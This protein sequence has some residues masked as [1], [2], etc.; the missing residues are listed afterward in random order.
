MDEEEKIT[1]PEDLQIE[2]LKFFLKTSIPRSIREKEKEKEKQRL[3][4]QQDGQ[5]NNKFSV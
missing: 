4:A 2:M 3:E 1:L 5:N